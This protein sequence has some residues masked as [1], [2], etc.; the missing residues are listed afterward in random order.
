[1][2]IDKYLLSSVFRAPEGDPPPPPPPP[3]PPPKPWYDGQVDSETLGHWQNRGWQNKTA[4]EIAI[5]ATKAHR[6]AEKFIGV[7]PSELL[8]LPK[9]AADPNWTGVWNRLGKP[10]DTNGYKLDDVKGAD[11]KP[12]AEPLAKAIKEAAFASNLPA[13]AAPAIASA[14]QKALDATAGS[15]AAEQEA[16]LAEGRQA[17]ATNW[18]ANMEVNKFVAKQGAMKLGLTPEMVEG[19]EKVTGYATLMEAMRRVGEITG[20]H[21]F[22]A[23]GDPALNGGVMTYEQA[24]AK[25]E[26]LM[27]DTAWKASYLE[28]DATKV[29]EMTA[30]NTIIVEARR[31]KN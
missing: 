6:E 21:K 18:G 29:R 25:K 22:V 13:S 20:E 3:E 15:A 8:R 24:L 23:S 11:G 31:P 16:K 28:G 30:L 9:D 4:A 2:L 1:M 5:E 7:P 19:L 27:N 10:V 26:S 12:I 17:L 14:V